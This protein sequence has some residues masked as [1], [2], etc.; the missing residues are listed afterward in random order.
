ML[1]AC[2]QPEVQEAAAE[3]EEHA[4]R[5]TCGGSAVRRNIVSAEKSR[6]DGVVRLRRA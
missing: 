1:L 6:D 2:A 5:P 4:R 3:A